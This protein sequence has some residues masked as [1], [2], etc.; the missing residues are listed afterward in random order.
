MDL[1]LIKKII[2]L[3]AASDV[4]EVAI[5]EEDL[6]IKVKKLSE[7]PQFSYTQP[8]ITQAPQSTAPALTQNT[9]SSNLSLI[10]I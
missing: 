7:T 9:E 6:K 4:N 10:H 5:E 8:M 2:D 3:I 1:K